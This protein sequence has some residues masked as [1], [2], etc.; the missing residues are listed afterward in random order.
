MLQSDELARARGL[1]AD[2]FGELESRIR[3]QRA[4]L[5][6]MLARDEVKPI[7][8]ARHAFL[9]LSGLDAR[10]AEQDQR[11]IATRFFRLW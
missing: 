3:E 4:T 10:L 5:G 11:R 1:D 9:H 6:A 8:P 7:L 2:D